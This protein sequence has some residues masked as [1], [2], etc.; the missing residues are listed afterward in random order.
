MDSCILNAYV[1]QV[2]CV[3]R[4]LYGLCINVALQQFQMMQ[5][6]LISHCFHF[7]LKHQVVALF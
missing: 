2:F 5:L 6:E 3:A 1:V 4:I 7:R